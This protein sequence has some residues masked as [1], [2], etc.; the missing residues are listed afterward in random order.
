[1]PDVTSNQARVAVVEL[2]NGGP[3]A[4]AE[5]TASGAFTISSTTGVGD[6]VAS[7][8]LSRIAPNPSGNRFNVSFSLL[9]GAPASL[10]IFDVSGRRVAT[11]EV[12]SLGAGFHA[13]SFGD[14]EPMRAGLYMVR[15]SQLSRNLTTSVLILP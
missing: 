5:I 13:V 9:S 4:E 6:G 10:S 15:L 3:D 11:R 1:M 14:R 8:A 7:F 2:R 12:G